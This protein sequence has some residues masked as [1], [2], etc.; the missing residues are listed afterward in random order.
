MSL[1]ASTTTRK[2]ARAA[3]RRPAPA[4]SEP[5]AGPPR[6]AI[7]QALADCRFNAEAA[8]IV[9]LGKA[10][11]E[12]V[13][14]FTDKYDADGLVDGLRV[15]GL[16]GYHLAHHR[17]TA[18]NVLHDM[19][20]LANVLDLYISCIGSEIIPAFDLPDGPPRKPR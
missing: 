1:T 8:E 13:E 2:P 11:L 12:A 14:R 4:A 5:D 17:T 10:L 16:G 15:A 20:G 18:G 3:G 6:A 9:R 7:W 19:A